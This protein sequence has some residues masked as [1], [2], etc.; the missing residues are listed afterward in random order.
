MNLLD[1]PWIRRLIRDPKRNLPFVVF[2]G[3]ALVV[4]TVTAVA[5]AVTRPDQDLVEARTAVASPSP[6]VQATA[7][8]SPAPTP[9]MTPASATPPLATPTGRSTSDHSP[10]PTD[11]G[12]V[13]EPVYV[14]EEI[15]LE[16]EV[17]LQVGRTGGGAAF[18]IE[19]G[20]SVDQVLQLVTHDLDRSDCSLTQAYEPDH[21]DG[22][23]WTLALKPRSRQTVSMPDGRH[24]FVAV[25]QSSA[26]ELTAITRAVAMDRKPE[27]CR[28]FRF[29]R[30]EISAN[31]FE[32]L[33][34]GVVGTWKGCATT[35][36]TTMY[37]VTVTLRDNGTYSAAT[38]EVLDGIRMIALY[39][40]TDDDD[41][42]KVYAINDFQDSRL[43]I[44]HIDISLAKGE[45]VRDSLRNVRLMGD[46][47][48][49]EVFHLDRYG[50]ITLRL[51]RQ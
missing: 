30:G 31:T 38:T 22:T 7:P 19:T 5:L 44:G 9:S 26:G 14:D 10:D 24:T 21:P 15:V 42:S 37:E 28:D 48:E 50:P 40:G 16:P 51:Y 25:C 1:R 23:P 47:L 4:I 20:D 33:T 18:L 2:G 49:L 8:S 36:W 45:A 34:A 11:D 32:E 12:V 39:Y 6:R 29:E 27:A 35:P 46:Q 3:L 13:D 43:G 41:P 17:I